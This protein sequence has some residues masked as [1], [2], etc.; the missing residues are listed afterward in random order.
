[1]VA[2]CIDN[3]NSLGAKAMES[4][5]KTKPVLYSPVSLR[6]VL[7]KPRSAPNAQVLAILVIGTLLLYGYAAGQ[8]GQSLHSGAKIGDTLTRANTYCEAQVKTPMVSVI[9]TS[10][11]R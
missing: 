1:M 2:K 7:S 11:N 3:A 5:D 9:Q 6:L 8:V 4:L 10:L